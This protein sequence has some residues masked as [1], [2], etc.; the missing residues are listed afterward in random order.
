[1]KTKRNPQRV[2]KLMEFTKEH[3]AESLDVWLTRCDELWFRMKK[4]RRALR[5]GNTL[6]A[7]DALDQRRVP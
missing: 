6:A 4:A 5:A 1:M 3:L 2:Q 7:L